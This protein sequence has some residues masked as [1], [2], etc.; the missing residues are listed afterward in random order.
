MLMS[1]VI[2]VPGH[3]ITQISMFCSN[4]IRKTSRGPEEGSWPHEESKENVHFDLYEFVSEK[5]K[6]N[7]MLWLLSAGEK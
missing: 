1:S 3:G 7:F 6:C 2:F 5:R 4:I